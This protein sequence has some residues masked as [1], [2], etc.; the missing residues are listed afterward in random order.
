[1]AEQ[2]TDWQQNSK[3]SGILPKSMRS[4]WLRCRRP[5]SSCL[6]WLDVSL[7][8]LGLKT[9]A[10]WE[11]LSLFKLLL[12]IQKGKLQMQTCV[13]PA[14]LTGE[15]LN[16]NISICIPAWL[17]LPIVTAKATTNLAVVASPMST[18]NSPFGSSA[19]TIPPALS[20]IQSIG[21]IS[22]WIKSL[23]LALVGIKKSL[24]WSSSWGEVSN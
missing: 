4:L 15:R 13:V 17:L 22:H 1:M 24:K 11:T 20:S 21:N 9:K 7:G 19:N 8:M 16:R 3:W 23:L 5:N 12:H 2:G 10:K 6:R 14:G 18:C